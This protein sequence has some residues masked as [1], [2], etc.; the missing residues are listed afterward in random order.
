MKLEH[1]FF[2]LFALLWAATGML[3]MHYRGE[4]MYERRLG[5]LSRQAPA[6]PQVAPAAQ[7]TPPAAAVPAPDLAAAARLALQQQLEQA[8]NEKNLLSTQV[9]KLQANQEPSPAGTTATTS[10]VETPA[11]PEASTLTDMQR[12]IKEAPAIATIQRYLP[13][14]GFAVLDAGTARGL[15]S[16]QMYAVRRGHFIVAKQIEIGETVEENESIAGVNASSLPTGETIKPGDEVIKW[17]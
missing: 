15:K 10:T 1:F 3:A 17:E 13:D 9:Q 4:L 5:E 7:P 8:E 2:G 11:A 12:K 14:Q 6:I 16:G